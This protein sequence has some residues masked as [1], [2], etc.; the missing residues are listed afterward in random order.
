MSPALNGSLAIWHF[1][2]SDVI[3]ICDGITFD[4]TRDCHIYTGHHI[5]H[6]I[7]CILHPIYMWQSHVEVEG[8]SVAYFDHIAAFEAPYR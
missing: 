4:F 7:T 8:Y 6:P 1:A 2:G 5:L 3:K